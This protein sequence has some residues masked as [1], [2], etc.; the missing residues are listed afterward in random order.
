MEVAGQVD[1]YLVQL[2]TDVESTD[3]DLDRQIATHI[4]QTFRNRWWGLFT[5]YDIPGLPRTN[6]EM[7]T[8]LRRLR[9]GQR[10]VTGRKKVHDFIVQYGWLVAFLDAS[11]S[12]A[13]LLERLGQVAYE[14]F[15][16]ERKQLDAV[17]QW[18]ASRHRF[19]HKRVVFF[20]QLEERWAA[21]CA[22]GPPAS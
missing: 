12:Q 17:Q 21:L 20:R 22:P 6:N 18:T 9:T 13:D 15:L 2:I 3:D 8:F 16:R 19:R 11:E 10:R 5:C 7:E 4:N 1:Q 14:D